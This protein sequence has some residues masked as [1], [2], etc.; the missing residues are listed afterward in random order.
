MTITEKMM[1]KEEKMWSMKIKEE[2]RFQAEAIA[3]QTLS[4]GN[5]WSMS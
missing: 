5:R 4:G 2:I 3:I 1:L